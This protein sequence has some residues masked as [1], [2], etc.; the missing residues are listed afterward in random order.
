MS[1]VD[2]GGRGIP[3]NDY[4]LCERPLIIILKLG[5]ANHTCANAANELHFFLPERI[6]LSSERAKSLYTSILRFF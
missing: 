5:Y 4:V 1:K 2:Y 6:V 3:K